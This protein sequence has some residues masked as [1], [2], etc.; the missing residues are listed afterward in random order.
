[1]MADEGP[2]HSQDDSSTSRFTYHFDRSSSGGTRR[3]GSSLKKY[4]KDFKVGP[5]FL[6]DQLSVSSKAGMATFFQ[7][8]KKNFFSH[9]VFHFFCR[10]VMFWNYYIGSGNIIGS[11]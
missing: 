5:I 1:M 2:S 8:N 9:L 4:L 7:V 6:D 3:Q 11:L 10:N